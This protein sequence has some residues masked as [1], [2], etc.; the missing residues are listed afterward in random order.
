MT[1]VFTDPATRYMAG[2][3]QLRAGRIPDAVATFRDV[4]ALDPAHAGARRNLIRALI[5]A[6]DYEAVIAETSI[7]LCQSPESAELHFLRGTA[8][9]AL[10]DPVQGRRALS[11]AVTLNPG[12]TPAWLNLGNT[13]VDTDDLATAEGHCRHALDLDPTLVEAHVSLGFILTTQGRLKEAIIAL[14]EAIRIQPDNIQAHWN[15]ATA[16]LLAGDL[17]RGLKEYE[18]R[19]KHDLFRRDFIN[20]PGPIWDGSNPGGR[21]ILAHAEQGLGDTIQFARFL[22]LLARCGGR[23]ILACEPSL[24]LLLS[25]IAGVH[26]VS[27]FDPL[28]QYDAWID[29]MSLPYAFGTTLD[30]IPSRGGYMTA[31]PGLIA[32]HRSRLPP[33]RCIGLAWTG[34]PLH[35][36][37]Q[38]RTP[39]M[40]AFTPLQALQH[41]HIVSLVPHRTL[42]GVALPPRP[43]TDYAETAALI[44]ALD[45]VITIDTSV[46]HVAGALGRPAWVLLPH[47]PDWRWLLGRSDSPWYDSVRLFRQPSPGDWRS[48]MARV[49]AALAERNEIGLTDRN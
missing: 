29:Q 23:P 42:P 46:A 1:L 48:V 14:E 16:A 44:A 26:V 37:D 35:R 6:R 19:K 30:T 28:P 13:F 27:K 4:L 20:L 3:N 10:F 49:V 2:L 17:P 8:F 40:D 33:G 21:T 41:C 12:L 32:A 9:N 39:P 7:A 22:P 43:L 11:T 34:N 18:H 24:I 45:L 15:L 36:N 25:K 38:R 5:A 31:D 47:A